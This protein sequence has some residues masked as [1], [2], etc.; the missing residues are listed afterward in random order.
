[1]GKTRKAVILA[2]GTVSITQKRSN[3]GG[4]FG[5]FSLSQA[6]AWLMYDSVNFI[7]QLAEHCEE[8]HMLILD[9]PGT[10]VTHDKGSLLKSL[11]ALL[12]GHIGDNGVNANFEKTK[13]FLIKQ[14]KEAEEAGE[15][16]IVCAVGW[17]RGGFVLNQTKEWLERQ[18]AAGSI[19]LQAFYLHCIDSV[20]GGPTDR[21]RYFLKVP[22][23][24]EKVPMNLEVHNYLSNT[25][26]LNLWEQLIGLLPKKYQINTPFFSAFLDNTK[27]L[28]FFANE[29]EFT[30][31]SNTWLFP[32]SHEAL[33][34]K[35]K[36]KTEQW[37]GDIV[38]ANIIRNFIE[39]SFNLNE[40]W[41][42]KVLRKG[43][44]ALEELR[45]GDIKLNS[46]RKY[47]DFDDAIATLFGRDSTEDDRI[48]S[49]ISIRN[50]HGN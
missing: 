24:S 49:C 37:A 22:N 32:A 2:N 12:D 42:N 7:N 31:C 20:V 1:M 6:T 3:K 16:L 33:V 39:L 28:T 21:L 11:G 10:D 8:K 18:I 29:L 48:H 26:N 25:G 50:F 46:C 40:D 38:L 13:E 34:G 47:L 44:I 35:P 41:A 45:K 4:Y 9:G 15:T 19:K 30:H 27:S 5:F 43:Q 36:N 17:S 23:S 14:S